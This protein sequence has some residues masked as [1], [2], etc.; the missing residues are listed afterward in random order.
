MRHDVEADL[1]T[2]GKPMGNGVPVS[3]L[4]GRGEILARFGDE[5][6][7]FNTFGGNTVSIAAAQAVLD[8]IQDEDLI[9][10]VARI[11]ALLKDRI[12]ALQPRFPVMADVRGVGLYIGAEIVKPG[13]TE[14][15][16]GLALAIVNGMR[17]R[18]VLISVAGPGNNVL[19]I[20]PPLVFGDAE[21]ELFM[22]AFEST[23]E[24][25]ATP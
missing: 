14:P 5:I 1:V 9:T 6:P 12:T 18:Q 22:T 15:D 20:R 11:G 23:L 10:S 8:F 4:A 7:Y 17:E 19:K 13:T 21:L 16:S 3:A 24:E 2:T 25:L